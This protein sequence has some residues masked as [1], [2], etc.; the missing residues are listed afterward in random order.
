MLDRFLS[1]AQCRGEKP[2]RLPEPTRRWLPSLGQIDR[3]LELDR[4]KLKMPV[5]AQELPVP[6]VPHRIVWPSLHGSPPL[7]EGLGL[8]PEIKIRRR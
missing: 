6:E 1:G 3:V 8:V 4:S 2:V 5:G 7:F